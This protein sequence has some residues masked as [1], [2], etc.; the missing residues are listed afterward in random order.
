MIHGMAELKKV[1]LQ[2]K[3]GGGEWN[4]IECYQDPNLSYFEQA[5]L[6]ELKCAVTTWT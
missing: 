5:I 3:S 6:K 4:N 1:E 2:L